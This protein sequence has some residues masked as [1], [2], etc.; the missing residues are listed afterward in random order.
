MKTTRLLIRCF[1]SSTTMTQSRNSL[2]NQPS[3]Y[4][5]RYFVEGNC[6][7]TY[8]FLCWSDKLNPL[9]KSSPH[10]DP[11]QISLYQKHQN[12]MPNQRISFSLPLTSFRDTGKRRG[13]C[14]FSYLKATETTDKVYKALQSRMIS[15]SDVLLQKTKGDL[16]GARQKNYGLQLVSCY[17]RL[18]K[19]HTSLNSH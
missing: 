13:R 12:Y 1:N 19:C 9:S 15:F 8:V 2:G 17:G 11:F 4:D 14:P 3:P 16:F 6:T 5:E 18:T 10:P 7:E